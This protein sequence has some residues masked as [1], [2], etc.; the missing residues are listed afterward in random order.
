MMRLSAHVW[1]DY[2]GSSSYSFPR[3]VHVLASQH[4]DTKFPNTGLETHI[5]EALFRSIIDRAFVIGNRW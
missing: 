4:T 3:S 1:L 5:R 2:D